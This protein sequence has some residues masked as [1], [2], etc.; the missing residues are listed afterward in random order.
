MQEHDSTTD[1]HGNDVSRF[2]AEAIEALRDD[3]RTAKVLCDHHS[4]GMIQVFFAKKYVDGDTLQTAQDHG[5][6]LNHATTRA[7]GAVD[8]PVSTRA[9][10]AELSPVENDPDTGSDY[11]IK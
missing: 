6:E 7:A 3:P 10:Y 4:T 8:Y 2:V 11:R 9:G 5:Y 1:K